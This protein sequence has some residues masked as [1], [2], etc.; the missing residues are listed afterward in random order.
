MAQSFRIGKRTGKLGKKNMSRRHRSYSIINL[1]QNTKKI[2]ADLTRLAVTQNPV[3][4]H[5]QMPV[6]K[7]HY[8]GVTKIIS[9]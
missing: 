1:T 2:P 7:K 4:N 3:E 9:K 8:K 5:H 6:R